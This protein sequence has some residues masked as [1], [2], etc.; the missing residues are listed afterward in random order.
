MA[1]RKQHNLDP[2]E[3]AQEPEEIG[4]RKHSHP[5]TS[6]SEESEREF[7]ALSYQAAPAPAERLYLCTAVGTRER[8][9]AVGDQPN[10]PPDALFQVV[11]PD[12]MRS[13]LLWEF[14]GSEFSSS[15][16]VGRSH[17]R[18]VTSPSEQT[19]YAL[20]FHE[21]SHEEDSDVFVG[22]DFRG[23]FWQVALD[24]DPD[25]R[26]PVVKPFAVSGDRG[27]PEQLS[28]EIG[29]F[30][31]MASSGRN[32]FVSDFCAGCA[33]T[34]V[35]RFNSFTGELEWERELDPPRIGL[36]GPTARLPWILD[37]DRRKSRLYLAANST[38][39]RYSLDLVLEKSYDIH[40][41]SS[42]RGGAPLG[43][44]QPVAPTRVRNR[45]FAVQDEF[46]VYVS[47]DDRDVTRYVESLGLVPAG[48]IRSLWAWDLARDACVSLVG[49]VNSLEQVVGRHASGEARPWTEFPTY[50]DAS[51]EAM[52]AAR[53][54]L[55]F[56]LASAMSSRAVSPA[57]DAASR[58]MWVLEDRTEA[59]LVAEIQA[60]LNQKVGELA[61]FN[62]GQSSP[63][64]AGLEYHWTLL[65]RPRGGTANLESTFRPSMAEMMPDLPGVYVVE[66]M[67]VDPWT[68]RRASTILNLDVDPA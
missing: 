50:T 58:A 32:I 3:T 59:P 13:E 67:V 65:D 20:S 16:R 39:R 28:V 1:S 30:L 56:S 53:T 66:L 43:F 57:L 36:Q 47:Q 40:S 33:G 6:V 17:A 22:V 18:G 19:L 27:E 12:E 25:T 21:F 60:S 64:D 14:S 38:V 26:R 68:R 62:G 15:A 4:Q 45:G 34:R 24:D 37:V 29:T 35:R 54:E 8:A 42:G 44:G 46:L 11:Y 49:S 2:W 61:I 41:D 9:R 48:P 51:L 23:R 63:R 52:G 55:W 10:P 7:G 31:D 5:V